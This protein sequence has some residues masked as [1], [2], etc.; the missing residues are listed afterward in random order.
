MSFKAHKQT[1]EE[2]LHLAAAGKAREAFA[3]YVGPGF[4]HHNVH[5]KGDADSLMTAMEEN[6]RQAP[7]KEFE[8]KHALE[9]GDMVAVHSLVK[10]KPGDRGAAVVHI[11]RFEHD[12]IVE[13][14]DLGQAVPEETVNENGMF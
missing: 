12:K 2:F 10:Q 4:K 11:F 8:I 3:L 9:D 1:V 6:A 14:W 13:L 7:G 5:F